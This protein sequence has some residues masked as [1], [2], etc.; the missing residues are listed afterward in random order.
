MAMGITEL[1]QEEIDSVLGSVKQ[2]GEYDRQL[3]AFVEGDQPGV[4]VA[5]DT[6]HFANKKPNSVKTGFEGAKNRAAK[7]NE[8]WAAAAQNVRVLVHEDNIYLI[9]TDTQSEAA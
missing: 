1:S 2:R 4:R 3:R 6:G 9:R 7:A 8:P 5:L